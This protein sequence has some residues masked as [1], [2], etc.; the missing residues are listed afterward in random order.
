[1]DEAFTI[2]SLQDRRE[3]LTDLAADLRHTSLVGLSDSLDTTA[4][5]L[6]PQVIE[7]GFEGIVAKRKGS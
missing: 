2:V 1:M 6:I 7:F 3:L 4:A 5:E